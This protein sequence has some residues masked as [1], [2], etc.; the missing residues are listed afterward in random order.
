[1]LSNPCQEIKI[2]TKGIPKRWPV[3]NTMWK[4]KPGSRKYLNTGRILVVDYIG[5]GYYISLCDHDNAE[6]GISRYKLIKYFER[7]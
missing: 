1:M 5:S 6:S 3:I 7:C 4:P 2:N